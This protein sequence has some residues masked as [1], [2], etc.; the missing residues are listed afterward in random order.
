VDAL[1]WISPTI[2]GMDGIQWFFTMDLVDG[3][4]F[5]D[6]VRPGGELDEARLRSALPQLVS[7]IMSLHGQ[8]VVHRDLKPSNVL[9]RD[10]GQVVILDFGLVVEIQ[11]WTDEKRDNRTND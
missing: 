5:L 9:V 4:D 3:V 8:H 2:G 7:G 10:E 11:Q 1:T 6:Y